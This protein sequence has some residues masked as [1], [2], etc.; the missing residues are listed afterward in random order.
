AW[1][2]NALGEQ[3]GAPDR[4]PGAPDGRPILTFGDAYAWEHWLAEHYASSDGVWLRFAKKR[5]GVTTVN[6]SEA[7]DVALCFGWIDSQVRKLDITSYLQRWTPRRPRSPWSQVNREKVA[8]LVAQDRMRPAGTREVERAKADG[9]WEHAYQRQSAA[10]VPDDL[11]AALDAEPAAAA[12]FET[13]S[14]QNRY[15]VLYR[16]QDAK[17]PATRARRIATF[18]AMLAEGKTLH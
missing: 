13:L 3:P 16:V 9:R 6:Y 10:T 2:D 1:R 17:R 14:S 7:L 11:R 4:Q 15:A 18:V 12:F 8:V 5:S